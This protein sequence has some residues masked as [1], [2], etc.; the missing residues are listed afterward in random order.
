[1]RSHRSAARCT[2]LLCISSMCTLC[3]CFE[4][5]LLVV[6]T[7]RERTA[8]TTGQF[9]E[10]H[11]QRR[12]EVHPCTRERDVWMPSVG[13]GARSGSGGSSASIGTW[14]QSL[15]LHNVVASLETCLA[16]TDVRI[17]W[18]HTVPSKASLRGRFA[19]IE[20]RSAEWQEWPTHRAR[21][22]HNP[23][24]ALPLHQR[25]PKVHRPK[26]AQTLTVWSVANDWGA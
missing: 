3:S 9:P 22:W 21:R 10:W 6:F 8:A 11:T 7:S 14:R 26:G 17:L 18:E 24:T 5:G 1:M 2:C 16:R 19:C 23:H 25:Y 13:I 20:G 12:G 4:S 15:K